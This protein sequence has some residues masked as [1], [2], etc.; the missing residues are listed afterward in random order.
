MTHTNGQTA[1]R[2]VGN[3]SPTERAARE[4]LFGLFE[5]CPIP[6]EERLANLGLF[7]NRQS[8]GRLLFL[9][10]L[11]RRILPVEGVVMELGVRWGQT[12][13]L[14]SSFRGLYEPF[15]YT[16]RIIGFD[17]FEGFPSVSEHDRSS[18]VTGVG[19]YAVTEDYDEY[20]RDVLACHEQ[21]SPVSHIPKYEV[22]RGDVVQ[23]LP[24]Y[25]EDHPETIVALVFM[26][27]DLYE[28]TRVCLEALRPHLTRGSV[29]GFD[30]LN[31][32][33]FPGETLAVRE[34]LG[35]DRI[36]LERSPLVSYPA[37]AVVD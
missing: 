27:V 10:E 36:R 30:E 37:F 26:D 15:N 32:P 28:P 17:T 21:E 18:D 16:R 19:A 29:I 20:I 8:M 25:L 4:R 2:V 5:D 1:F 31:C 11:Y 14:F 22:V 23:T 33:E 7:V 35:L 3:A 12:L 6:P 34:V 9:H 13:A 24:R